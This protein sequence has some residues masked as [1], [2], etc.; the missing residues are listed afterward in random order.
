LF[1]KGLIV[2]KPKGFIKKPPLEVRGHSKYY[3][4]ACLSFL[5]YSRRINAA[6]NEVMTSSKKN[7]Q[8]SQF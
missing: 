4:V 7:C 6:K 3:L 8:S 5:R 2:E 1:S